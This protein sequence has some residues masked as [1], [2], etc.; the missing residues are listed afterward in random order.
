[1]A[2]S[3]TSY[4]YPL[5]VALPA[6]SHGIAA[7]STAQVQVV[8]H[9]VDATL[10][11]PTSAVHTTGTD[12]SYVFV[13][14]SGQEVRK[15]ISV[16][17]VGGVYTQVTSGITEGTTVVLAHLSEAVPTSS[18]N[19]STRGFGGAG[20]GGGGSFRGGAGASLGG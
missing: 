5:I 18:T 13:L 19:T 17:V 2:T 20:F 15:K 4:T 11:V 10:A 3:G 9:E 16:G 6:G 12:S 8:L 1:M 14:E 7:G